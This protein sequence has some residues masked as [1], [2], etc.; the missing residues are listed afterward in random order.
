MEMDACIDL[1]VLLSVILIQSLTRGKV[2]EKKDITR[3]KIPSKIGL[4][5]K[6]FTLCVLHAATISILHCR[7]IF[8]W[9]NALKHFKPIGF[10]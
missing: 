4:F 2:K 10:V 8:N 3:K 6:V 9:F 5:Y 1:M 7:L